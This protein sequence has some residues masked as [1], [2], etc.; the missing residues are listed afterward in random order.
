[1][2]DILGELAG[3]A[4]LCQRHIGALKDIGVNEEDVVVR[5][6]AR[7]NRLWLTTQEADDYM[8]ELS[9]MHKWIDNAEMPYMRRIFLR[10]I[11]ANEGLYAMSFVVH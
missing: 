2:S 10:A 4:R 8:R 3:G 11:V 6:L 5:T 1:M 7:R 9:D